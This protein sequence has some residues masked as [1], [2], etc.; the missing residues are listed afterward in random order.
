M[1]KISV[2]RALTRLTIPQEDWA[3]IYAL[4]LARAKSMDRLTLQKVLR[5][6]TLILEHGAL[7]LDVIYMTR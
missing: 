4:T 7:T 2:T 1:L 6:V 3:R 5:Y